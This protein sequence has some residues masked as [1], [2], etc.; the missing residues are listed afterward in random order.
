MKYFVGT[1]IARARGFAGV[2]YILLP[3]VYPGFLKG[4]GPH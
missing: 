1:V 2:L 4:G 3:E